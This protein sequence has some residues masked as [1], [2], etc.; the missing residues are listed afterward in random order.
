MEAADHQRLLT[1]IE[2]EGFAELEGERHERALRR[3]AGL[4]SPATDEFGDPRIAP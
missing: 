2:L 3:L 4:G 1:P